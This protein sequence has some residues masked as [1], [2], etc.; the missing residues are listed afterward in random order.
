VRKPVDAH[1]HNSFGWFVHVTTHE[2]WTQF[3]RL[4]EAALARPRRNVDTLGLHL[5]QSR[6]DFMYQ[7]FGSGCRNSPWSP[8]LRSQQF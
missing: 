1:F 7:P 2:P 6:Y 5:D 8:L 3:G 4:N